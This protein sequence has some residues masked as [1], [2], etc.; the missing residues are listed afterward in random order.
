MDA[1]DGWSLIFFAVHAPRKDLV[2]Y[3]LQHG[4]S[5]HIVTSHG[6]P[7]IAFVILSEANR[8]VADM[9]KV[10][11]EYGADVTAIPHFGENSHR[12][13]MTDWMGENR[14]EMELRLDARLTEDVK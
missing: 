6:I 8:D 14:W 9:V 3:F 11:E 7:L 2:R 4:T 1:Y 13:Q 5:P 10:V 12:E